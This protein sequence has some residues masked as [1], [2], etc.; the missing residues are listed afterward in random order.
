MRILMRKEYVRTSYHTQNVIAKTENSIY[1][2][3]TK[4]TLSSIPNMGNPFV[5]LLIM[6]SYAAI[7]LFVWT[8]FEKRLNVV[9]RRHVE[10]C[11]PFGER[12][13]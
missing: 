11:A 3:E 7:L 4:T 2:Y 5:T 13:L 12:G 9:Y 6:G 10:K 1:S 8:V